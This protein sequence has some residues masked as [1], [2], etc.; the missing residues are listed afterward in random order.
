[1][2]VAACSALLIFGFP[3]H[4]SSGSSAL[5]LDRHGRSRTARE[6]ETARRNE[7]ASVEKL[8]SARS[9]YHHTPP[10]LSPPVPPDGRFIPLKKS[11]LV[12]PSSMGVAERKAD[13]AFPPGLNPGLPGFPISSN[14]SDT[15]QQ[16]WLSSYA[17]QLAASEDE[18]V[19]IARDLSG[20]LYV[21]GYSDSSVTGN[22]IVTMKFTSGGTRL[23]ASRYSGSAQGDDRPSKII[24]DSSGNTYVCGYSQGSGSGY[25][26]VTIKYNTGGVQQWVARYDGQAGGNDYATAIARDGQG[27]IYVTGY[28][29]GSGTGYDYA[30]VKYSPAG[31]EQQVFRHNGS[32]NGDDFAVAIGIDGLNSVYVTGT[33]A[34]AGSGKDCATI[35]YDAAGNKRWTAVY[36][37]PGNG[38]DLAAGL[39]VDNSAN[40]YV[41]GYARSTGAGDDFATIKYDSAGGQQWV[42]TYNGPANDADHAS[43][44][45]VDGAGTVYVTGSSRAAGTGYDFATL[46]Y[47]TAGVQAWVARYDGA[48]GGDEFASA[49]AIDPSGFVYVTGSSSDATTVL[50]NEATVM[51]SPAGAQQWASRYK[52]SQSN[53]SYPAAMVNDGGGGVIVAGYSDLEEGNGFDYS[54]ICYAFTGS[55]VWDARYNGPGISDDAATAVASDK[56][57]NVYVAGYSRSTTSGYDFLTVKYNSSGTFQWAQRYDGPSGGDDIVSAIATDA[58]GNVYVAGYSYDSSGTTSEYATVK[59]NSG[60][61]LQWV[62]RFGGLLESTN[63]AFDIA[64]TNTGSIFVT[65]TAGDSSGSAYD[66]L[67]VKYNSSGVEQW[68]ARFNGSG[69]GGDFGIA[70]ATDSTGNA[71]VTGASD[72]SASRG[73]DMRTV[74]Y[75]G[76]GSLLWGVR[77]NGTASDD[78]EGTA[79][80]VDASGNVDVTG[81]SLGPLSSYDY[82]T[83]QY[84][85]AGVQQW[86]R[87]YN[88]SAN[89]DDTP[90]A[91]TLGPGGSVFV[92]GY[93]TSTGAAADYATLSYTAAGTQRWVKLYNGP[94]GGNDQASG[95]SADA[96]GNVY[97]TGFSEGAGTLD[98]YATLKYDSLGNQEWLIRFN[99][100]AS[101]NDDAAGI[102]LDPAGGIIVAGS[103]GF[104]LAGEPS[105]GSTFTT[106]KYQQ[107]SGT[108][109]SI[110]PGTG[111]QLISLPVRV[112][113]PYLL[114]HLYSYEGGYVKH[115]SM[116][117]GVGYWKK[118]DQ[119]DLS[120]TGFAISPE[121]LHVS[122]AWN[123]VGSVSV[124]V[125]VAS[126]SSSPPG[127]ILSPFF[128]YSGSYFVA[129]SI[130]PGHGYWV[131]TS[132][133]GTLM[134]QPPQSTASRSAGPDIL[135][136]IDRGT[137]TDAAGRTGSVYFGEG[138]GEAA[139]SGRFQLPPLPPPGGFDVR[140]KD[141]SLVALAGSNGI[142]RFGISLAGARFPINFSCSRPG[143]SPGAWLQAG[144]KRIPLRG[145]VRTRLG[146]QDTPLVLVLEGMNDLPGRFELSQNY[147]NPFNPA[148]LIR[149]S[150]PQESRV[151]LGIYDLLGRRVK[152]LIDEIED[153]GF[154]AIEWDA[155]D[156]SGKPV[157]SGVY[158]CRMDAWSPAS[159]GAGFT[160]VKR[161]V[162]LR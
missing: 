155:L 40:V 58:A 35:K 79:I 101:V 51:Y 150:L 125:P 62:A 161:M 90:S 4:R 134:L 25:D 100:N 95:L 91:L 21:T 78:D 28:S 53:D 130:L 145:T 1:V 127:I 9:R 3:E 107:V 142:R 151:R 60:G 136:R 158:F 119:P 82:A 12:R 154:K 99:G 112:G 144:P 92:T 114:D 87:R 29:A 76:N 32:G 111:W 73:Y 126:I 93:S 89:D 13:E 23:W 138:R 143:D 113:S 19:A 59:Y 7:R 45:A 6:R 80:A 16:Q 122:D 146:E 94:A 33:V 67:T 104:G 10:G 131:R 137:F 18:A 115:D 123:I 49:I 81:S 153:A 135:R 8:I 30:T 147:P 48:F 98:D 162:L 77:Y 121:T 26:Y 159:P 139:S 118:L 116:V 140:F 42:R 15:V 105:G 41:T 44:I 66:Y 5:A 47:S 128:G 157:S 39:G 36:N 22:D 63:F 65:G 88:G 20:N 72:E 61:A 96:Q 69:D 124:P 84:N 85:S 2:I 74:K 70:V 86:V 106:I 156:E 132:A 52:S 11:N 133:A 56:T 27:N 64:V 37:G 152:V 38:D 14:L 17:S 83:V 31:S 109:I 160:S 43:A 141:G 102:A 34:S 117:N 75:N 46:K 71:F 103:S 57:G 108:V 129:D 120:F 24:V 97:V 148:T 68:N 55:Q 54:V 50:F 149:Y 110:S